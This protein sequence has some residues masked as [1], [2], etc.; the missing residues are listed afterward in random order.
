MFNC[1]YKFY[2]PGEH[3][4]FDNNYRFIDVFDVCA[5][6]PLDKTVPGT[7]VDLNK[8]PVRKLK[9]NP[10]QIEIM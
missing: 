2:K 10:K 1:H 9:S 8:F 5:G 4:R 3:N 6:L 7:T